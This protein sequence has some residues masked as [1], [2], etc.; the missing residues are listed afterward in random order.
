IEKSKDF[1]LRQSATVGDC[2]SEL[3]YREQHIWRFF[4]VAL[5]RKS[6]KSK[7]S[8]HGRRQSIEFPELTKYTFLQQVHTV[9]P[10]G[11]GGPIPSRMFLIE[12]STVN[13]SIVANND[14][15]EVKIFIVVRF[16]VEFSRRSNELVD[17]MEFFIRTNRME[18]CE[19]ITEKLSNGSKNLLFLVYVDSSSAKNTAFGTQID[20]TKFMPPEYVQTVN[21]DVEIERPQTRIEYSRQIGQPAQYP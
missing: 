18:K 14:V 4:R 20:V 1:C 3:D 13:D 21:S 15:I 12:N 19:L 9:Q 16:K 10:E 6:V 5:L 11:N 17:F 8:T 2:T 7:P